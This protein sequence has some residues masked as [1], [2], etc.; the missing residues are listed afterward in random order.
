MRMPVLRY[1]V[2]VGAVLLGLLYWAGD[3]GESGT[4][5]LKTSQTVGLPKSFNPQPQ[6]Q[7]QLQLQPLPE[8]TAVNFASEYEHSQTKA[9]KTVE[10]KPVK[11]TET[12]RKDKTA[13][14]HQPAWHRFVEY[15]RDNLSIR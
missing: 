6:L 13:T 14:R 11:N 10:A 15:P 8:K 7:L 12:K 4:P 2:V 1:F 5:A 3:K 9:A